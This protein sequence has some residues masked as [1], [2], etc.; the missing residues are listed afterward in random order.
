MKSED[1][2]FLIRKF[3]KGGQIYAEEAVP[4]VIQYVQDTKYREIDSSTAI[5]VINIFGQ[6]VFKSL[7]EYYIPKL[8]MPLRKLY[9]KQGMLIKEW[10]E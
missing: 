1:I 10:I 6:N 3:L 9:N 7:I 4:L 8:Q 2:E 5:N